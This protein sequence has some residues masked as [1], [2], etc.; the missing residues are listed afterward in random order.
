MLMNLVNTVPRVDAKD[1]ENMIN[2]SMNVGVA[3]SAGLTLLLLSLSPGSSDGS[4]SLASGQSS[5]GSQRE[6]HVNLEKNKSSTHF[7]R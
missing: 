2:T 6:A 4:I 5:A 3:R 7:F 1:L